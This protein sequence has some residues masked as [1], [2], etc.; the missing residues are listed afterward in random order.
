[1]NGRFPAMTSLSQL[2]R[3]IVCAVRSQLQSGA[4]DAKVDDIVVYNREPTI[5]GLLCDLSAPSPP[6]VTAIAARLRRVSLVIK[7]A[8]LPLDGLGMVAL[9]E[10]GIP[11]EL[12]YASFDGSPWPHDAS[13]QGFAIFDELGETC[14]SPGAVP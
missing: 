13:H 4:F 9:D 11:V 5:V 7:H 1:M 8:D 10:L 6:G 12:E 14:L 3:R 2:E